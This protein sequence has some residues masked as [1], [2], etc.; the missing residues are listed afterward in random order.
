MAH[1]SSLNSII[2]PQI[3][4]MGG[5]VSISGGSGGGGVVWSDT[6]GMVSVYR[7]IPVTLV[8]SVAQ[9]LGI[10]QDM[11]DMS[12]DTL[13]KY[14]KELVEYVD[15]NLD[16]ATFNKKFAVAARLNGWE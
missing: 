13:M 15:G 8:E 10:G 9:E 3:S 7:S 16:L 12:S 11:P 5:T 6:S 2:P 14:L 4:G 1:M